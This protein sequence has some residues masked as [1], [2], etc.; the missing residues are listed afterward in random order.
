MTQL[1]RLSMLTGCLATLGDSAR[2]RF[3]VRD[4]TER[5][6]FRS[7]EC[8]KDRHAARQALARRRWARRL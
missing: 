2:R 5:L 4:I 1:C 7:S 6:R 8:H 3:N